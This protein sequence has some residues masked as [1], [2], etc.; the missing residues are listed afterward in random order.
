LAVVCIMGAG[1]LLSSFVLLK[2]SVSL[3][4]P[5]AYILSDDRGD[6]DSSVG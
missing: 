5:A 6:A 4:S 1:R 3:V 2:G